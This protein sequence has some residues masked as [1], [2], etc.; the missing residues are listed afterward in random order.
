MLADPNGLAVRLWWAQVRYQR[1]EQPPHD[2][3]ELDSAIDCL[4]EC[5]GLVGAGEVED[6]GKVRLR[7]GT[8]LCLR[9]GSEGDDLFAEGVDLLVRAVDDLR[10]NPAERVLALR[11]LAGM[12]PT[13]YA[14]TRDLRWLRLGLDAAR[15]ARQ[16]GGSSEDVASSAENL[17]VNLLQMFAHSQDVLVLREGM[18]AFQEAVRTTEGE[19][20]VM[21]RRICG[22][23]G[24]FTSLYEVEKDH[25]HL[26]L[27]EELVRIALRMAPAD[28]PETPA[29]LDRLASTLRAYYPVQQDV[30]RMEEAVEASAAAAAAAPRT[31]SDRLMFQLT[32]MG[33]LLELY[34]KTDASPLLTAADQISAELLA[35]VPERHVARAT[36]LR[37]R[38][39]VEL[40]LGDAGQGLRLLE[41]SARTPDVLSRRLRAARHAAHEAGRAG[42]WQRAAAMLA[43]AVSLLPKLAPRHLTRL[44]QERLL[45]GSVGLAREACAYAIQAGDPVAALVVLEHGRGIL[46]RQLLEDR[47]DLFELRLVR[48]DLAARVDACRAVF[49]SVDP[50]SRDA[51]HAAAEEWERIEAELTELPG[52]ER[53]FAGPDFAELRAAAVDGP[54]IVVNVAAL[55]TDALVLTTK[56]VEVV[57]LPDAGA[58]AAQERFR[59][60]VTTFQDGRGEL[61]LDVLSWLWDAIAEP[62]LDRL[63]LGPH[64]EGSPWP[65]IWWSP[66]G[67]LVFLPL[68]H[69]GRHGTNG[70]AVM[71]RAVS[72]NTSSVRALTRARSRPLASSGSRLAVI[73]A[74]EPPRFDPL[75]AARRE[76]DRV[77]A[78]V[79]SPSA[80]LI[81]P[82]RAETMETLATSERVHLVCHVDQSVRMPTAARLVLADH[83]QN[84]LTLRDIAQLDLEHAEFAYLSACASGR[85]GIALTEEAI[86]LATAFQAAGYRHVVATLWPIGDAAACTF[87]D[88]VYRVIRTEGVDGTAHAVHRTARALRKKP[89]VMWAA[90]LHFGP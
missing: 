60:L 65:R 28:H 89:P 78:H 41:A 84:P 15:E 27:A 80:V 31:G 81:N 53:L 69:A 50:A 40:R 63:G 74:P 9:W 58:A 44:D 71:D 52:F 25:E 86:D 85:G 59:T 68:A 47:D 51:A 46:L 19:G 49:A 57:E 20:L 66:T 76:V 5:L 7:L 62:V 43:E 42:E 72:S 35:V 18:A 2:V 77:L 32:H 21:A 29:M 26:E 10:G 48:P 83:E 34:S 37:I 54:V 70:D 23:A 33:V 14:T 4:R 17:A 75:P 82:T 79:S 36:V 1:Y 13:R 56:G 11:N 3:A 64:E 8:A 24:S 6:L 67:P 38:G 30:P 12:T 39:I 55:R 61:V 16:H 22:L 73:A 87:S 90:F 88:S 45:A